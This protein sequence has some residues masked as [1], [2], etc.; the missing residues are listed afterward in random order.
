MKLTAAVLVF[1]DSR[2]QMFNG[3][4]AEVEI[5]KLPILLYM[6]GGLLFYSE[7]ICYRSVYIEKRGPVTFCFMTGFGCCFFYGCDFC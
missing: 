2:K 6:Y 1:L 5:A 7:I 4:K 3:Q